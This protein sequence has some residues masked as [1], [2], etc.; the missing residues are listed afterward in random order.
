MVDFVLTAFAFLSHYRQGGGFSVSPLEFKDV[1]H[2]AGLVGYTTADDILFF[3][4]LIAVCDTL[5]LQ[6]AAD[7]QKAQSKSKPKG[8]RHGR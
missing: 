7:K 6:R 2:Y 8:G 3:A 5:Y 4:R 1:T